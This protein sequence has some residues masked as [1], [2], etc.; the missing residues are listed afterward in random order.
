MGSHHAMRRP[1]AADK[2]IVGHGRSFRII[3]IVLLKQMLIVYGW[4][5]SGVVD[6]GRRSVVELEEIIVV[7]RTATP[8]RSAAGHVAAERD[9]FTVTSLLFW[10]KISGGIEVGRKFAVRQVQAATSSLR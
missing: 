10:R 9:R 7:A 1:S 4:P 5:L 3:D 6:G 8:R 2:V